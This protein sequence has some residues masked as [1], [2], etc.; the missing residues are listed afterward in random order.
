MAAEVGFEP[1]D[2]F[3]PTVFKTAAISQTRPLRHIFNQEEIVTVATV[4]LLLHKYTHIVSGCYLYSD[5]NAGT[6]TTH[7]YAHCFYVLTYLFEGSYLFY[8][9]H[10]R[11]LF[12]QFCISS[13]Q[14]CRGGF[15]F[16]ALPYRVLRSYKPVL[17]GLR[18]PSHPKSGANIRL[19]YRVLYFRT[20]F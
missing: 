11:T 6:S 13:R 2:G 9:T 3:P 17:L 5:K 19:L 8:H 15:G 14:L 10:V 7:M 18:M 1:T 16:S 12:P 20:A 4:D